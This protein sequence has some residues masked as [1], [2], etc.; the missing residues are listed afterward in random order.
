MV[1]N[2]YTFMNNLMIDIET[3][4]VKQ[5]AV[6]LSIGA[7]FF[8]LEGLIGSEY[9]K[10]ISINSCIELGLEVDESTLKFWI[11]QPNES[12]KDLFSN[13]DFLFYSLKQLSLLI[14]ENTC[15]WGNP[16]SFDIG[17]LTNAFNKCNIKIPWNYRNIRDL[18][19][20]T[21]FYPKI[22][23]EIEFTG[24]K[25]NAIDDCKHQIK[26]LQK[27]YSQEIYPSYIK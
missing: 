19:T 25:H 23:D 18:R 4:S 6:I 8:D 12:K 21:A 13:T 1:I 15:V 16:S 26:I 9:Y 22:K 20:L 27:I 7:V 24:V 3:L 10:K 11:E 2:Q 5:N 14:D 17:I